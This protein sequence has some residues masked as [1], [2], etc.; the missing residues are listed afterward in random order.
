MKALLFAVLVTISINTLAH[1]DTLNFSC[2]NQSNASDIITLTVTEN[3]NL[4]VAVRTDSE[5]VT[6]NYRF[7]SES[8]GRQIFTGSVGGKTAFWERIS[9]LTTTEGAL[10]IGGE[11]QIDQTYYTCTKSQN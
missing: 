7:L 6:G 9:N 11:V 8:E 3:N 2:V 10:S 1:A 5:A 4:A